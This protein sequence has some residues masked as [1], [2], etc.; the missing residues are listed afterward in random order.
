MFY[1][2]VFYYK[3][4]Y[5]LTAMTPS[6]LLFVLHLNQ[7]YK[8][9]LIYNL[10]F[11]EI[12]IVIDVYWISVLI[13]LFSVLL[14][15]TLK[16]LLIY[17]YSNPSTDQV[18]GE[19]KKYFSPRSLEEIN[20]GVISFL[21]GNILPAVVI[22]GDEIST[23]LFSF[24]F[25]QFILYIL[26]MKSTDAFPNIMLIIFRM[27]LCKTQNGDYV[28]TFNS[29]RYSGLKIYQLGDPLKSK[30]YITMYNEKGI[31]DDA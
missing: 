9:M 13:T 11:N 29:K 25:L 1:G 16:Y 10:N 14:T 17:Q 24:I 27:N 26:I 21:L 18:L 7:E 28:F 6:Y 23:T 4:L 8:N 15:W 19:S 5:F 22:V 12:K 31:D 3:V 30:T 20:G 2:T